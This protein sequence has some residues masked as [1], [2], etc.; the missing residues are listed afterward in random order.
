MPLETATFISQFTPANPVVGDDVS[1][2]DDH[3]RMIKSV[4]Q[5]TFPNASKAFYFPSSITETSGD[6]TVSGTDAGKVYPVNANAA[7]RTVSLPAAPA[8]GFDVTITKTDASVNA[9]T[10]DPAGA[11]TI[12]GATTLTLTKQFESIKCV[13]LATFA[14]W[15]GFRSGAGTP[16]DLSQVLPIANGG[17]GQDTA[18]EAFDALSTARADVASAS[19]IDLDANNSNYARITGVTTIT[20]ITLASGRKRWCVFA[21]ILT[22]THGS[23]LLLPT[24]AN[25]VTAAGDVALFVGEAANIVRCIGYMRAD[26]TALFGTLAATQA[27]MEAASE[28]DAYSSPGR[29]HF[30]PAHPKAGGNFDGTGTPAFRS[31]DVGM[32]TITD[33]STGNFTLSLDTAFSST[34]YWITAWAQNSTGVSRRS[35]LSGNGGDTKTTSS[36]QVKHDQFDGSASPTDPPQVGVMFWGD[37][38]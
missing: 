34:D 4:L 1:Q 20:A 32:G 8:D 16:F 18:A 35:A 5:T 31:G 2:G 19:T 28:V 36:M 38:A 11:V 6:V 25:I 3:I 27:E 24:G 33:N 12:N 29:Q 13:Y 9:V 37:Y 30:H 23:L 21:D 15:V 17:T 10:I 14:V 26:G 7:T 22:L